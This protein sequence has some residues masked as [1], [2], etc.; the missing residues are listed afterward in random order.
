MNKT[1]HCPT[2]PEPLNVDFSLPANSIHQI[3][4]LN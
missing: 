1:I 3:K 2:V 4:M